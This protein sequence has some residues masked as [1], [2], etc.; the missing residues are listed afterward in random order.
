RLVRAL[1]AVRQPHR[2]A[3]DGKDAVV[4]VG[5]AGGDGE[6]VLQQV[7]GDLAV[8][9]ERLVV[10]LARGV[11]AEGGDEVAPPGLAPFAVEAGPVV[12]ELGQRDLAGGDVDHPAGRG[13]HRLH[14]AGGERAAR[15]GTGDDVE[16]ELGGDQ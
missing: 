11:A 10:R 9:A 4:A 1:A 2:R 3:A 14:G 12:L 7:G 15:R 16:G 13:G 8:E 6:Q 5:A